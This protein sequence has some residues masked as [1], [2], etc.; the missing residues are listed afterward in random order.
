MRLWAA[1]EHLEDEDLLEMLNAG[2]IPL[3]VVDDSKARLWAQVLPAIQ[4]HDDLV[5]REGGDIAFAFRKGSPQL[6]LALDAFVKKSAKGTLFGNVVFCK[7]LTEGDFV[8]NAAA[9]KERRKLE[10][11]SPSSAA[12]V[13]TTASTIL[14]WQRRAT[15]NRSSTIPSAAPLALWA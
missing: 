14:C 10:I 8:K 1:D 7:Y 3:V 12:S 4:T 6:K 11:S 2:L 5:L 13:T 9:D 15:R